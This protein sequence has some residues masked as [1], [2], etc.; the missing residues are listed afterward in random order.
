MLKEVKF[1]QK[2]LINILKVFL[3]FFKQSESIEKK[4]LG[5]NFLCVSKKINLVYRLSECI[6]IHFNIF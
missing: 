2:V 5:E 1:S 3:T 4:S 6:K